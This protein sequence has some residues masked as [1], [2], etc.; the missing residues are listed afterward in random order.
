[1]YATNFMI[2]RQYANVM[3]RALERV[4]WPR[5][6]ILDY[7]AGE[8]DMSIVLLELGAHVVA[9]EPY[10]HGPAQGKRAETV[11]ALEQITGKHEFDGI[12]MTEVIEHVRDPIGVL[13][14]LK[15]YLKREGWIFVTTP[16]NQSLRARLLRGRWPERLKYGHLH[17]FS[18][19]ALGKSL[20]AA[21]F[22]GVLACPGVVRFSNNA[23]RFI[24]QYLLQLLHLD[25][26]LR[27]VAWNTNGD[28]H[29][30]RS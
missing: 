2:A 24:P 26:Q 14:K 18:R 21:G 28:P 15:S 27:V 5:L 4:D 6:R 17:L 3:K 9:V 25:G 16:N 20:T 1:M 30:P 19:R 22:G 10:G 7:G 11:R 23:A 8:G 12:V 29:R 13:R